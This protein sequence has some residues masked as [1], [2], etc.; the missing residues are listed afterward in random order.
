MQVTAQH[1]GCKVGAIPSAGQGTT[2]GH[3]LVEAAQAVFA[4]ASGAG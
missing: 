2:R 1:G 3:C 4:C